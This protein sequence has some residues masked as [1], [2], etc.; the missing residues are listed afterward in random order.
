MK[1]SDDEIR[2]VYMNINRERGEKQSRQTADSKKTNE[3]QRIEHRCCKMNGAFAQRR[4][5][6]EN[7]Y[8]RWNGDEKAKDGENHAGINRLTRNKHVVTPNKK[9]ENSDRHA[10]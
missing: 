8:A 1:M 6:I 10:G 4:R 5:P 9:S 2:V 7:F 3:T